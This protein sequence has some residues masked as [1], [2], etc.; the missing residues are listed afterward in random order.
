MCVGWQGGL[1]AATPHR[2]AYQVQANIG[3]AFVIQ[4]KRVSQIK[5]QRSF[6]KQ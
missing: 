6:F 2:K 3:V 5:L 1:A 4:T